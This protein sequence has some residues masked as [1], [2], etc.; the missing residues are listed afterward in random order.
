MRHQVSPPTP[1]QPPC[2]V[3]RLS[4]PSLA[5]ASG[6]ATCN[7]TL[8]PDGTPK[9]LAYRR[10]DWPSPPAADAATPSWQPQLGTAPTFLHKDAQGACCMNL[11]AAVF[12]NVTQKVFLHF[13]VG[14]KNPSGESVMLVTEDYGV[15]WHKVTLSRTRFYQNPWMASS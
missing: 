14:F 1:P 10:S 2:P 5:A 4:E 15:S 6:S 13:T 12:D 9:A 7:P 11:G 8:A 3:G